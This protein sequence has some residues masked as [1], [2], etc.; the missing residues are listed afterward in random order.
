MESFIPLVLISI[1]IF[2]QIKKYKDMCKYLSNTYPEE[3]EKLSRNSLGTSPLSVTNANLSE[4]LKT[5]FFSKKI[6]DERVKRF[7]KFRLINMYVMGAIVLIQLV[8]AYSQ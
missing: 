2:V 5:G 6:N 7:E 3:W 1:L 4:S 8:L